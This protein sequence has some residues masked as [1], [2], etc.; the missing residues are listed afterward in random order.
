MHR[1]KCT[2]L[3]T[4]PMDICVK[5]TCCVDA[6][7]IIQRLLFIVVV[8]RY[9]TAFFSAHQELSA[10]VL[11]F[12]ATMYKIFPSDFYSFEFMRVVGMAPTLGSDVGECFEAAEKI[13]NDDPESWYTAWSEAA[14][15]A[16]WA[17]TQAIQRG[18]RETALWGFMRSSNYRRASEL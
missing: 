11:K 5:K 12:Y 8:R 10:I 15:N 3:S 6:N 16:E 18:D 7:Y 13:K 14:E 9:P 17:G 2:D 4:E 1:L